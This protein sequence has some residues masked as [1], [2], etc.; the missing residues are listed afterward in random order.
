MRYVERS[1]IKHC[2]NDIIRANDVGAARSKSIAAELTRS[3]KHPVERTKN[4]GMPAVDDYFLQDGRALK[5][6]R[7]LVRG[8]V[9]DATKPL[10]K[11]PPFLRA[12][13]SVLKKRGFGG[14]L[15]PAHPVSQSVRVGYV[16]CQQETFVGGDDE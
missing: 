12:C 3:S 13:T 6:G 8:F 14:S 9:V 7:N 1:E 15:C 16:V 11:F 4:N 5:N 10:T 2:K